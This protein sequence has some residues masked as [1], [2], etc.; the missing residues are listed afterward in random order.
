MKSNNSIDVA[1]DIPKDVKIKNNISSIKL[2]INKNI[3]SEFLISKSD[4]EIVSKESETGKEVDLSKIPENIKITV[5]YS[6]EIKDLSQKDIQLYIDMA[7]TSQ[8]EGKYPIK[9]KSKYDFKDVQIEP[10]IVEI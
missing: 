2:N 6:D 3:T 8:G 10:K 9:Y 5:S 7:D 1:L 4:I